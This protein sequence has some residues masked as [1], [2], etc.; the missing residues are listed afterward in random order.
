MGVFLVNRIFVVILFRL[1]DDDVGGNGLLLIGIFAED[2][3]SEGFSCRLI[4]VDGLGLLKL[5]RE[6]P[7]NVKSRMKKF[8]KNEFVKFQNAALIYHRLNFYQS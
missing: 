8:Q 5:V 1:F 3:F 2:E 4:I 7:K 6:L